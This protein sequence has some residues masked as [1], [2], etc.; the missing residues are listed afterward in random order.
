MDVVVGSGPLARTLARSLASIRS[1]VTFASE[2][3]AEGPFL[4]RRANP[5]TGEGVVAALHDAD[6]AYVVLERAAPA[7]GV[8]AAIERLAIPRGIAVVPFGSGKIPALAGRD[9]WSYLEVG[10]CW[11]AEE[12]LLAAWSSTIARGGHLRWFDPGPVFP[13][14]M[15]EAVQAVHAAL[16]RPGIHWRLPGSRASLAE[17]AAELGWF[18]RHPL[19]AT[20]VA[21]ASGLRRLGLPKDHIAFWTRIPASER[22]TGDWSWGEPRGPAGWFADLSQRNAVLPPIVDPGVSSL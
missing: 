8:F 4:W 15:P 10:P 12:P 7:H 13:V 18:H 21:P 17:L 14:P 22:D 19:R 20:R 3:V 9:G 6:R 16:E 5:V 11:G 1:N 2:A